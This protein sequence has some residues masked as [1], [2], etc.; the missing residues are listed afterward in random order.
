MLYNEEK[1]IENVIKSFH[2]EGVPIYDYLAISID[3]KTTDNTY[4]IVKQFCPESNIMWFDFN[5]DFGGSRNKL[6]KECENVDAD[7]VFMPD[8][9]EI[10]REDSVDAVKYIV[11]KDDDDIRLLAPYVDMDPDENNIPKISFPRPMFFRNKKGIFFEKAVHNYLFDSKGGA[12]K[13][14]EIRLTHLMPKKRKED[15]V[16]QRKEMNIKKLLENAKKGDV[17]DTFYLAN[18]YA[19]IGKIKKAIKW[20]EKT[21]KLT[22]KKDTDMNSQCAIFL[23]NCYVLSEKWDDVKRVAFHG[24]RNRWDRAELYFYLGLRAGTLA[25]KHEIGS[26]GH[27]AYHDQARHWFTIASHTRMPETQHFLQMDVYTWKAWDGLMQSLA[28]LGDLEGAL[29]SARKVLEYKPKAEYVKNN[30]A[31]LEKAIRDKNN[32]NGAKESNNEELNKLDDF[33]K[34]IIKEEPDVSTV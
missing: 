24:I 30:I 7:W 11:E 29:F 21:L 17:R 18:T 23:C 2:K 6:L 1:T 16:K 4:G 25:K 20:Y 19:E 13:I 22:D 26:H 15:R 32:N 28:N 5:D 31:K 10:L 8:G 14:P 9:H 12:I 33:F 3:N 27:I 34:N